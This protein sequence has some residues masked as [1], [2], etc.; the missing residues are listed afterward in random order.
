MLTLFFIFLN[1]FQT[2]KT[3]NPKTPDVAGSFYSDQ[4]EKL[5]YDMQELVKI[6][7]AKLKLHNYSA[8]KIALVPHAGMKYSGLAQAAIYNH[9]KKTANPEKIIILAPSH[10][11]SFDYVATSSSKYFEI[12]TGKLNNITQS[13]AALKVDLFK[14]N[15]AAFKNEHSL[16]IQLPW[17]KHFFPN[18]KI[19]PLVVGQISDKKINSIAKVILE[20]IDKKCFIVATTDLIHYGPNY[21][22]EIF[23]DNTNEKI[24]LYETEI[25]N[26]IINQDYQGFIQTTKKHGANLCGINPVKIVLKALSLS[27]NRLHTELGCYYTSNHS[28]ALKN[29]AFFS[30]SITNLKEK[31]KNSVGYTGIT[32]HE[33]ANEKKSE[34]LHLALN[35][36]EKHHLLEIGKSTLDKHFS[37]NSD[38]KKLPTPKFSTK[39][40]LQ[41]Y[42]VFST[43]KKDKALRGCI[44]FTST[45]EPLI[46][47]A[48][49]TTKL[50]AFSDSRFPPLT[51]KEWPLDL[52]LTILGDP[53]S[54]TKTELKKKFVLGKHGISISFKNKSAIFLPKVPVEQKWTLDQTLEQL[55]LK[56]GMTNEEFSNAKINLIEGHD[57]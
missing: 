48:E 55:K 46:N 24:R 1:L 23:L 36:F 28:K 20:L 56:A 9:I 19:I 49:Q 6:A 14:I 52:S 50:A 8:S 43:L 26:K 42:G 18:A 17:I 12:P 32:F 34:N 40:L 3:L 7:E 27:K 31:I 53:F 10:F 33:K 37:S 13:E 25:I 11:Q 15:D 2:A 44:G 5:N 57:F 41:N 29:N 45:Q 51:K 30:N 38:L 35:D 47:S 4:P 54:V 16:E 22:Y 21:N 39:N